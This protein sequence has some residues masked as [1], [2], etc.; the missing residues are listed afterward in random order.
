[1]V[2]E[3]LTLGRAGSEKGAAGAD[4]VAALFVH[5]LINKEVLLLR[6]NGGEDALHVVLAEEPEH[7]QG[8]TRESVHGAQQGRLLVEGLAAVGAEGR[9]DA[10]RV[11]LD[12]GVA[13]RVPG[14]VAAGLEGGAQ[15]AGGEGGRVRLA[16]DELT[17]G[18][19]HD[20]AAVGR[21]AYEA[22]VLLGGNA[23]HGLEPVREVRCTALD[24]PVLHGRGDLARNVGIERAPGING[25]LEGIIYPAGEPGLHCP[26][27]KNHTSKVFGN[28]RHDDHLFEEIKSGRGAAANA[29][30]A[31]LPYNANNISSLVQFV[32]RLLAKISTIVKKPS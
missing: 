20:D 27:V 7:A 1:M 21:G 25:L 31:P 9:W 19:L 6:T 5:L 11:A 8:L 10:E 26:V 15:A 29:A 4:Q 2:V 17:A 23:G 16:L 28:C 3:L 22:V 24:R 14:G 30:A 13:C 12:E 18:E 32:K